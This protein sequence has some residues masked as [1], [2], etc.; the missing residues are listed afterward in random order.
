M[1]SKYSETTE[2]LRIQGLKDSGL[3]DT[4]KYSKK[5]IQG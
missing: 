1:I 4:N 3:S 2:V 5:D